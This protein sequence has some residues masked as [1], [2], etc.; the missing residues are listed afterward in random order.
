VAAGGLWVLGNP[1]RRLLARQDATA[2]E[3]PA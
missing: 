2:V 1:V 3:V